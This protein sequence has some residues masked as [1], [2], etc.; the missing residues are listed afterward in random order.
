MHELP[1]HAADD[2]STCG[3]CSLC[4][5][6]PADTTPQDAPYKGWKLVG[7][8]TWYFLVPILPA[9]TGAALAGDDPTRRWLG[10]VIGLVLGMVLAATTA[11][12]ASRDDHHRMEHR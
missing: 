2:G 9:I 6:S 10:G 11:R 4:E 7:W 3:G 1:G 8:A 5:T 12:R